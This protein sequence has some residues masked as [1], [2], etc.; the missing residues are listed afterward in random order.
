MISNAAIA[1][2]KQPFNLNL[3]TSLA[4]ISRQSPFTKNVNKPK[5]RNVIGNE[6]NTRTGL[7]VIL[8][9]ANTNAAI[10]AEKKLS[11]SKSPVRLPTA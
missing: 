3:G 7:I 6:M 11:I 8:T 1:D 4:T 2:V 10:M 5:V 9:R